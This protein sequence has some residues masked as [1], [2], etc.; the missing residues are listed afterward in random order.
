VKARKRGRERPDVSAGRSAVFMITGMAVGQVITAVLFLLTARE[1]GREDFGRAAVVISIG[2]LLQAL[3][4]FGLTPHCVREIARGRMSVDEVSGRLLGKL[5]FVAA[6]GVVGAAVGQILGAGHLAWA[7]PVVAVGLAWSQSSQVV[8]RGNG[9]MGRAGTVI[10][11]ERLMAAA[12]FALFLGFGMSPASVLPWSIGLGC[13]IAG[14]VGWWLA[15]PDC[16]LRRTRHVGDP[17]EGS[18]A[19]GTFMGAVTLQNLDLSLLSLVAGSGA[20]GAYGA[21]NRWVSPLGLLGNAVSASA[22][23]SFARARH[24]VTAIRELRWAVA[25]L[26]IAIAASLGV[27]AW[28]DEIAISLLGSDYRDSGPAL[29]YLA[30]GMAVSILNQP[31]AG[32][33]MFGT[34][35]RVVGYGMIASVTLQMGVVALFGMKLGATAAGVAF[36][37]AQVNFFVIL[38]ILLWRSKGEVRSA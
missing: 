34:N 9:L 25:M 11:L 38:V 33:L 12:I 10:A 13:V 2:T 4:D 20:A 30:L 8:L 35:D 1:A 3:V 22:V 16:R 19:Y 27:A 5:L 23:T 6:A 32:L 28:G 18:R 37:I 7:I 17:W 31:L 21:V 24:V 15:P 14:A 36:L 29:T 26:L